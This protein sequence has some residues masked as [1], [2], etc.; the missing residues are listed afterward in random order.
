M[1]EDARL[2]TETDADVLDVR[3]EEVDGSKTPQI[4]PFPASE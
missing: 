2:A 1:V 4:Q 3:R